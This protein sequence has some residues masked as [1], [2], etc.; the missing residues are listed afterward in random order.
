[1]KQDHKEKENGKLELVVKALN[2]IS[3]VM[4]YISKVL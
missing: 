1:L 4:D 3:N 2:V